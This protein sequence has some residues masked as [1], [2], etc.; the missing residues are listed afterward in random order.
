VYWKVDL[1]AK[2][3]PITEMT[4][5][6]YAGTRLEL[7]PTR[8]PDLARNAMTCRNLLKTM[9]PTSG[10][11]P[12]TCWLRTRQRYQ[13]ATRVN[14]RI[15]IW[16]KSTSPLGDTMRSQESQVTGCFFAPT[17]SCA[18]QHRCLTTR[19]T[20]RRLAHFRNGCGLSRCTA[21]PNESPSAIVGGA[22]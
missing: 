16:Y 22:G 15:S 6:F 18:R 12:L 21:Q 14:P 5:Q 10:L 19:R 13:A 20:A 8:C 17:F 4:P 2:Q 1:E 3:E 7:L 11:E 9:E